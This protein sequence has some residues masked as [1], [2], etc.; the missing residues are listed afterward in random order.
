MSIRH[1]DTLNQPIFL[2]LNFDLKTSLHYLLRMSLSYKDALVLGKAVEPQVKP[3]PKK[4]YKTFSTGEIKKMCIWG[5]I[6]ELKQ[7]NPAVFTKL[8][9]ELFVKTM[10]DKLD[11]IAMW[12]YEDQNQYDDVL[13]EFAEREKGI[14]QCM[15][16]VK[17]FVELENSTAKPVDVS[18][19]CFDGKYEELAKIDTSKISPNTIETLII[20]L[21]EKIMEIEMWKTEEINQIESKQQ[22]LTNK[23][24]N[25]LQCVN[26]L[27][28]FYQTQTNSN[29]HEVNI[30]V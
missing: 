12:K 27:G 9:I 23:S 4:I 26:Y 8:A 5:K 19:V 25:I 16:Y 11:E 29:T 3:V 13:K 6:G 18:A 17:Y 10:Q 21:K 20:K 24:N 22:E 30:E 14:S 7:V 28:K 15:S 2:G 1:T